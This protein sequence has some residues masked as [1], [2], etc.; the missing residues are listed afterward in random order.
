M[1]SLNPHRH[2]LRVEGIL[3]PAPASKPLPSTVRIACEEYSRT[4]LDQL[5]R[6]VVG[7]PV[8]IEHDTGRI[9]G[10]VNKARRTTSN[11][12]WV[13]FTVEGATEDVLYAIESVHNGT[14]CGL[15]LSH[16][17]VFGASK[18]EHGR[19]QISMDSQLRSGDYAHKTTNELSLCADPARPGCHIHSVVEETCHQVSGMCVASKSG[20]VATPSTR[21]SGIVCASAMESEGCPS[22]EAIAA[23]VDPTPGDHVVESHAPL[24]GDPPQVELVASLPKVGEDDKIRQDSIDDAMQR[25]TAMLKASAQAT[26]EA[27]AERVAVLLE[28]DNLMAEHKQLTM[29]VQRQRDLVEQQTRSHAVQLQQAETARH[30][31]TLRCLQETLIACGQPSDKVTMPDLPEGDIDSNERHRIITNTAVNLAAQAEQAIKGLANNSQTTTAR[32][33]E[34]MQREKRAREESDATQ[35]R[36]SNLAK[37]LQH[38]GGGSGQYHNNGTVNASD[39]PREKV[40]KLA[41][42]VSEA[43]QEF[44]SG[45]PS[46]LWKDYKSHYNGLAGTVNASAGSLYGNGGPSNDPAELNAQQLHPA[47]F[48]TLMQMN[49]GRM[50]ASNEVQLM[51]DGMRKPIERMPRRY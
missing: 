49:K 13:D 15:S 24:L 47:L 23:P 51:Y 1:S 36:L 40:S 39:A 44:K 28:R 22:V 35:L 6:D 21:I 3:Y 43:M 8:C 14:M 38:F 41:Q 9:V 27:N 25:A 4:E 7:I 42:S 26:Q 11:A 33:T 48:Q 18:N 29:E 50:P 45:H 32:A 34:H 20:E 17:Y 5:T 30:L 2:R 31:Q 46:A 19:E 10:I 16:S 37:N 12:I